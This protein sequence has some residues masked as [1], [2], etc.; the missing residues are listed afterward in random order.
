MEGKIV[1]MILNS[2]FQRNSIY[3]SDVVA[4]EIPENM[5]KCSRKQFHEV[6]LLQICYCS[7][8]G[9]TMVVSEHVCVCVCV[10]DVCMW[11][12]YMCTQYLCKCWY[13]CGCVKEKLLLHYSCWSTY[14]L[15]Q[16]CVCYRHVCV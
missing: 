9:C 10:S 7:C 1:L 2:S 5:S 6:K 16:M 8:Y 11:C 15:V 14:S 13:V 12:V 4:V 3:Q